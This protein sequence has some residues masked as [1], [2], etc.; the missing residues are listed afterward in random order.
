L[1]LEGWL[2]FRRG[3][4]ADGRRRAWE[5]GSKKTTQHEI[6]NRKRRRGW[7]FATPWEECK[8]EGEQ[9]L[10]QNVANAAKG[11]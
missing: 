3:A 4:S 7:T 9:R 5:K 8:L 11:N 1:A 10:S 2:V 6:P